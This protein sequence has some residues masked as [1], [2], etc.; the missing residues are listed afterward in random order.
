MGRLMRLM[1]YQHIPIARLFAKASSAWVFGV[2]Y[3]RLGRV[4]RVDC[5]AGF[6]V[7]Q[8]FNGRSA[9]TATGNF[10][11]DVAVA[12]GFTKA[13]VGFPSAGYRKPTRNSRASAVCRLTMGRGGTSSPCGGDSK[14]GALIKADVPALVAGEVVRFFLEVASDDAEVSHATCRALELTDYIGIT[15][16]GWPRLRRRDRF[17]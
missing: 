14:T 15:V 4:A 9:E 8:P 13:A 3:D 11:P 17:R 5:R 12:G 1:K 16:V 2:V 6:R 10:W 7:M